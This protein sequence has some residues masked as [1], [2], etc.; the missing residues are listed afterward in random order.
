MSD[1]SSSDSEELDEEAEVMVSR[2]KS[3]KGNTDFVDLS[4]HP[5]SYLVATANM[6]GYMHMYVVSFAN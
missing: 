4:F 1:F 6:N 3:I 5:S 2:P